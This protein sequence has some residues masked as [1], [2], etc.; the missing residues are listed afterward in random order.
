LIISSGTGG[1]YPPLVPVA[2]VVK[3]K[4]DGAIALPLADPSAVSF[5]IVEPPYE[6]AA[7]ADE[8]QPSATAR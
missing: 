8:N 2:R 7:V 6:P 1:L 4:D 3:L 5:A